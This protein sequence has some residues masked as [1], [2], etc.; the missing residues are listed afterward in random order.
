MGEAARPFFRGSLLHLL[1]G[2]A[3][4]AFLF[5]ACGHRLGARARV[6]TFVLARCPVAQRRGVVRV[7]GFHLAIGRPRSCAGS[8]SRRPPTRSAARAPPRT[9]MA[10]PVLGR[11]PVELHPGRRASHAALAEALVEGRAAPLCAADARARA[12]SREPRDDLALS[13]PP[14]P[15]RSSAPRWPD[16][17]LELDVAVEA[18]RRDGKRVLASSGARHRVEED[19]RR[20]LDRP[21]DVR[22]QRRVRGRRRLWALRV[23]D[24]ARATTAAG[25]WPPTPSTAGRPRR[26]FASRRRR[27]AA[28]AA[29]AARRPRARARRCA[30]RSRSAA[31]CSARAGSARGSLRS[32]T[33][34]SSS[35]ARGRERPDLGAGPAWFE[36]W[37]TRL[38][39][40]A[41]A[42]VPVV[43]SYVVCRLTLVP[44]RSSA[45][46]EPEHARHH[47][48]CATR[49]DDTRARLFTRAF[50]RG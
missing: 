30:P 29:A 33:T 5:A 34:T 8:A 9:R 47:E 6:A 15:P 27:S 46:S 28:A 16:A 42:V 49:R 48:W 24:V 1:H 11:L 41:L 44:L 36:L 13:S 19:P 3:H 12:R 17:A 32:A 7:R 39:A 23:R 20:V 43:T 40:W 10:A 14:P 50:S 31:R 22:L 45:R 25:G 2:A 18:G 35:R 37:L 38:C 4:D 26:L 21:R